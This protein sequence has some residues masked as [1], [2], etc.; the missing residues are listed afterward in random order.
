[1]DY[2]IDTLL[3]LDCTQKIMLSNKSDLVLENVMMSGQRNYDDSDSSE[4]MD[5][6]G[7]DSDEE[8]S[9]DDNEDIGNDDDVLEEFILSFYNG[10]YDSELDD[11][12]SFNR[13]QINSW[14]TR[15]RIV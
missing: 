8:E 4:V 5:N 14:P 10:N 12:L 3:R 15:W 1:L 13:V 2:Y 7:E 11:A 9:D 6:L